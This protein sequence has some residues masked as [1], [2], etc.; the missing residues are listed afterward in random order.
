MWQAVNFTPPP[1][2]QELG[3]AL[4]EDVQSFCESLSQG[5]SGLGGLGL[6]S[7]PTPPDISSSLRAGATDMLASPVKFMAVTPYQYGVGQRKGENAYLTP[8]VAIKTVLGRVSDVAQEIKSGKGL[9]TLG[10]SALLMLLIATPEAGQLAQALGAFNE[11]YPIKEL[12]KIQRRAAAMATLEIDKFKIPAAPGYP[13]WQEAGALQNK[14]GLGV[15]RATGAQLAIAEGL[16]AASKGPS[17]VLGAFAAKLQAKAQE[18]QNQLKELTSGIFGDSSSWFDFYL[19]GPGLELARLAA[20]VAP[21]LPEIFKCCTV[22][23][24]AGPPEEVRYFKET[25]GLKGL[26]ALE[27]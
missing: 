27:D 11:V 9:G 25:F 3:E 20:K 17:E 15:A 5:A 16:Q 8:D 19:E 14:T 24:W 18:T 7:F 10:K 21:P 1:A 12:Q 6:P 4:K 22:L 2:V 13:A 23:A 26:L